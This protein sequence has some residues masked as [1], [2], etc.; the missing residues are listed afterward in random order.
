MSSKITRTYTI[1]NRNYYYF[2][3][4]I[5]VDRKPGVQPFMQLSSVE[6]NTQELHPA[7]C[8]DCCRTLWALDLVMSS[9]LQSVLLLESLIQGDPPPCCGLYQKLQLTPSVGLSQL[10][11]ANCFILCVCVFGLPVCLC[12]MCIQ[13]P[14]RLEECL[15]SPVTAVT[16]GC[17]PPHG[18]WD[19]NPGSSGRAARVVCFL[20]CFLADMD[21]TLMNLLLPARS[22]STFGWG[23]SLGCSSPCICGVSCPY[24]VNSENNSASG[25]VKVDTACRLGNVTLS[26]NW[27]VDRGVPKPIFSPCLWSEGLALSIIRSNC[28]S[29]KLGI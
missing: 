4:N 15:R 8:L 16:D 3:Q 21:K 5:T 10:I 29:P 18:C 24:P 17:E 6:R 14:W 1:S 20:F 19:S 9:L 2:S 26:V 23:L 12:T 11:A 22:H 13:C 7:R 25:P 28:E 27:K